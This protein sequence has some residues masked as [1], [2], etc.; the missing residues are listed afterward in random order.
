MD[1]QPGPGSRLR[2]WRAA[3]P[4]RRL[5]AAIAAVFFAYPLACLACS[6]PI[7]ALLTRLLLCL[8]LLLNGA[9]TAMAMP[10]MAATPQRTDAVISPHHAAEH[11]PAARVVATA[12]MPCHHHEAAAPA[13]EHGEGHCPRQAGKH[14]CCGT[15]TGCQC[16]H[17]PALIALPLALP[18]AAQAQF[19]H[20]RQDARGAPGLPRLER[21]PSA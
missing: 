18:V 6:V 20:G 1:A 5:P 13:A 16:A 7:F 9:G 3:T 19:P 8:S 15:A 2:R 14:G 17:A 21:P 12:A 10:G 4:C 11:A